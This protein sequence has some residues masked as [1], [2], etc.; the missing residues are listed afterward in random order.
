MFKGRKD[1]YTLLVPATMRLL[2]AKVSGFKMLIFANGVS[3]ILSYGFVL[4]FYCAGIY[5]NVFQFVLI[6]PD[7]SD[8]DRPSIS[9]LTRPISH[10]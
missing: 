5:N 6:F 4:H 7:D 2:Q 10:R 3:I 9:P 8:T 1:A